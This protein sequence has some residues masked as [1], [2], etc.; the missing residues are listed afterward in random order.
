MKTSRN[1]PCPCGSGKKYKA[2]C[3]ARDEARARARSVLGE[4]AFD[5][6]EAATLAAARQAVAWEADIAPAPGGI[7]ENP[8]AGLSLVMVAAGGFVL[9]GDVVPRRPV[10]AGE[11]A[12]E[13]AAAVNAAGRMAGV[14]PARVRVPDGGLAEAL[15][16]QLAGRGI[17]VEAG[18]SEALFDAMNAALANLDP[19]PAAGR[20]T[21]ALTWRETEASAREL[22]EFHEAAVAFYTATPW[23]LEESSFLL[24]LPREQ[25]EEDPPGLDL[26]ERGPWA[27]SLMGALG[28]SFGVALYSRPGDLAGILMADDPLEAALEGTG[29]SITV[30]FD[31]RSELTRPMQREITAAGWPIAGPRAYPRL[32]GMHLP[33]RRV[34]AR[35]VRV[36]TLALRAMA[37]HARGGDA[38]AEAGVRVEPFQFEEEEESR[39]DWFRFPDEAQPICPEGPG[40]EPEAGLRAWDTDEAELAVQAA[41]AERC[42]RLLTW[43]EGQGRSAIEMEADRQ[44]AEHWTDFLGRILPARAVTE[45]DLRLFLYSHY[46][47]K[48]GATIGATRELP[49]SMRLIFR[50]LAE[51]EGIRYPFAAGVLDELEEIQ[52]RAMEQDERLEDTLKILSYDLYPYLDS[53]VLIPLHEIPGVPGGWPVLMSLEIAQLRRELERRWLLWFDEMVRGGEVDHAVLED[54]LERRQ[55]AWENTPHPGVGGRTPAEVVAERQS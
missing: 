5:E 27:A 22:A 3:M 26:R 50:F 34:L 52:S 20:M 42:G 37:V 44:N 28:E 4:V 24:D 18:D 40:A 9:H 41:E 11:R 55:R 47:R 21:V 19:G 7:R 8:D 49:R 38:L 17:T 25:R 36:A 46:P 15:G 45:F 30:D 39:E 54:A 12:R 14:L 53:R 1:D 33:G 29:F 23:A 13:I 6:V 31:R 35:E 48:A 16:R 32:F 10:G 2:C 51:Q 43:L